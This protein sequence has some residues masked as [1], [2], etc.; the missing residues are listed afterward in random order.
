V[1]EV[2]DALWFREIRARQK[3]QENVEVGGA[4]YGVSC[5]KI[6]DIV[7]ITRITQFKR[8]KFS[9]SMKKDKRLRN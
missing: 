9:K 4:R 2:E 5:H 6:G 3:W 7:M 8:R 1:K